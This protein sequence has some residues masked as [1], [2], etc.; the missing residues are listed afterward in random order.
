[1]VKIPG[2]LSTASNKV[3]PPLFFLTIAIFAF[4]YAK[5]VDSTALKI[6]LGFTTLASSTI[7][8]YLLILSL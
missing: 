3:L 6:N 4:H 5:Q 8:L 2:W 1:M 7:S